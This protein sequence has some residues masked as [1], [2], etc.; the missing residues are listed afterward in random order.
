MGIPQRPPSCASTAYSCS[1]PY[2]SSN[3]AARP[4]YSSATGPLI[5][6]SPMLPYCSVLLSRCD[7]RDRRCISAVLPHTVSLQH[8]VHRTAPRAELQYCDRYLRYSRDHLAPHAI[9]VEP[10]DTDLMLHAAAELFS[11]RAMLYMVDAVSEWSTKHCLY[12]LRAS[13][14][15]SAPPEGARVV[16]PEV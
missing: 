10:H 16:P 9:H 8:H 4:K 11:V 1:R 5:C 13:S 7:C 3:I 2:T 6:P 12:M 15:F 14:C